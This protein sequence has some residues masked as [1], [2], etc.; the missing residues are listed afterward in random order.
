MGAL[1]T[2][3]ASFWLMMFCTAIAYFSTGRL[4]R[5]FKRHKLEKAWQQAECFHCH[6]TFL[7]KNS[8]IPISC[9][10]CSWTREE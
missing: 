7:A 5:K 3:I 1:E 9:P 8:H 6:N 2:Y 4:I 10:H